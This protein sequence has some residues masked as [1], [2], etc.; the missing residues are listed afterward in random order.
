ML[1][2]EGRRALEARTSCNATLSRESTG[3]LFIFEY[4]KVKQQEPMHYLRAAIRQSLIMNECKH[5]AG[6]RRSTTRPILRTSSL[7]SN[8]VFIHPNETN[9]SGCFKNQCFDKMV[10]RG[11][12]QHEWLKK[13]A[14]WISNLCVLAPTVLQDRNQ[15]PSMVA[16]NGRRLPITEIR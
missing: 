12:F 15:L 9:K 10:S 13:G 1:L 16:S 5:F 7:L 2:T 8:W 6:G 14:Y 3:N 4:V 11:F